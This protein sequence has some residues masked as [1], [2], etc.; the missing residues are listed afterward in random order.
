VQRDVPALS[1]QL[2]N[3]RFV[4]VE[5]RAPRLAL[6]PGRNPPRLAPAPVPVDRRGRANREPRRRR[7]RRHPRVNRFDN[8]L[9]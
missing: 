9:P 7:A 8:P 1:D 3:E 2:Q 4:R 5:L 6:T